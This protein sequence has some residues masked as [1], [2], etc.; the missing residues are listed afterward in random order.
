[1]KL[2]LIS[3]NSFSNCSIQYWVISFR[4]RFSE[5]ISSA[6]SAPMVAMPPV[7]IPQALLVYIPP[8]KG[9]ISFRA[10]GSKFIL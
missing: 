10:L 1:M 9:T 5:G 3:L 7:S 8:P 6:K 4:I 2:Q